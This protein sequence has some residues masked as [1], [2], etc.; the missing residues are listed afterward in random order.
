MLQQP[1]RTC[2]QRP[3][4]CNCLIFGEHRLY[5]DSPAMPY[6]TCWQC[7]KQCCRAACAASVTSSASAARLLASTWNQY[8]QE[9]L[10]FWFNSERGAFSFISTYGFD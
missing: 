9:H 2:W 8:Q 6:R 10:A 3:S 4:T 7:S 1:G 5:V